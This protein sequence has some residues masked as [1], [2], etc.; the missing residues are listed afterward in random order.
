[1][2]AALFVF[3]GNMVA[4]VLYGVVDPRIRAGSEAIDG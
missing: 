3:V 4:N 2:V 1:L